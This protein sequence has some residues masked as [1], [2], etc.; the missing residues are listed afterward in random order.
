MSVREWAAN[1]AFLFPLISLSC[2]DSPRSGFVEND[3][4]SLPFPSLKWKAGIGPN[5]G[6]GCFPVSPS[7]QGPG[8]ASVTLSFIAANSSLVSVGLVMVIQHP[9]ITP[10]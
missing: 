3:P 2:A 5:G 9:P 4:Q 1:T 10:R 7:V 8:V 6:Y